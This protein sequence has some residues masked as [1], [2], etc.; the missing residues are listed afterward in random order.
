M[1]LNVHSLYLSGVMINK[2]DHTICNYTMISEMLTEKSM[3]RFRSSCFTE[4]ACY[5]SEKVWRDS[6]LLFFQNERSTLPSWLLEK[7]GLFSV[8]F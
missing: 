1:E 8:F 4:Y 6:L 3:G 7:Y 5:E 2:L